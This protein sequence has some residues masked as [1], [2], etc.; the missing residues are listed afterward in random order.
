MELENNGLQA[1]LTE[2]ASRVSR[3]N[4]NCEV[5]APTFTKVYDNAAAIH[6]YRIA[7]EA[8]NNAIKHGRAKN[9]TVGLNTQNNQV[10]LTVQDDGCGLPKTPQKRNGMGLRVM[11]YRAGMIGATVSVS[12]GTQCGTVVRCV[13]PNRPLNQKAPRLTDGKKSTA[14]AQ[15]EPK[16]EAAAA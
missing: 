10:E 4:V 2:L 3:T 5:K 11:N 14:R 8:V 12:P 13:M 1:A 7:Q 16:E 6:L 9:I 15:R